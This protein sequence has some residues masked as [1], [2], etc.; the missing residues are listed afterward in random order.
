MTAVT[1]TLEIVFLDKG[2]ELVPIIK[3]LYKYIV[4]I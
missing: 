2:Y 3:T 1:H 4:F